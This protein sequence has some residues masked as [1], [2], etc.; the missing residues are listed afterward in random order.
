MKINTKFKH[1]GNLML[2][3]TGDL[4]EKE[5]EAIIIP[6]NGCLKK[7]NKAVVGKGVAK[8]ANEVF[9]KFDVK[10]GANL[11]LF[12]NIPSIVGV[13]NGKTVINFPTKPGLIMYGVDDSYE[14]IDKYKRLKKKGDLIPG[15]MCKSSTSLIESSAIGTKNIVDNH[16]FKR[17]ILPQ[18]GCGEGGLNLLN[19]IEILDKYFDDRFVMITKKEDA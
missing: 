3:E 8:Q 7:G 13:W 19:I 11:T 10:L 18:V 5:T 14:I 4:F 16:G 12:G 17:V 9:D 1:G 6:T 2:Y 15:W